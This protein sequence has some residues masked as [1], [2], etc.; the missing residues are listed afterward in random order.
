MRSINFQ[1]RAE[2]EPSGAIQG[3]TYGGVSWGGTYKPQETC[4]DA[5]SR[6]AVI[7][8]VDAHTFETNEGLCLDD[9][10]TCILEE[11]PSVRPTCE[12]REKGEC[13]WYA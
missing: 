12:E 7:K 2:Q 3:S 10:I 9:D 8:A 4:E 11:I 5:V 1:M 6:E 13:P